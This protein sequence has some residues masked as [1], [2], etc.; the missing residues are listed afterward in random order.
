MEEQSGR[1][2]EVVC[3]SEVRGVKRVKRG[4]EIGGVKRVKR[5]R[6]SEE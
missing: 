1:A 2:E 3:G 5:G 4:G 6:E